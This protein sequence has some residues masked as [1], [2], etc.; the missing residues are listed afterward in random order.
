MLLR[1]KHGPDFDVGFLMLRRARDE[2]M[3]KPRDGPM[4]L[5][6]DKPFHL[7]RDKPVLLPCDMIT[8]MPR[9]KTIL[10]QGNLVITALSCFCRRSQDVRNHRFPSSKWRRNGRI[11]PASGTGNG[12]GMPCCEWE[13]D[14]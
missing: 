2:T 14:N 13:I 8:H 11:K 10:C 7:A 6:R 1:N 9:D 12:R 4:H 5:P 3:R